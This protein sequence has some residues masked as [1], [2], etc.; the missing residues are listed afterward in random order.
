VTTVRKAVDE[1]HTSKRVATLTW[2]KEKINACLLE[3][4]LATTHGIATP[5][6]ENDDRYEHA[7]SNPDAAL[8][9]HLHAQV[10]GDQNIR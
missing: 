7:S 2:E 9:L 6:Q 3:Q 1:A 10:V 5:H 4:Q 8:L